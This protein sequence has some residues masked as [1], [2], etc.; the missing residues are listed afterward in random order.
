MSDL[1]RLLVELKVCW[2]TIC[3]YVGVSMCVC[4]H[5]LREARL[6]STQPTHTHL[7]SLSGEAKDRYSGSGAGV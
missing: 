7:K 2:R 1:V 6:A 3:G 4:V 5:D